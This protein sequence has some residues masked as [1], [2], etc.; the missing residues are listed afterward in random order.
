[1]NN[2]RSK[3]ILLKFMIFRD[4]V[5]IE[6]KTFKCIEKMNFTNLNSFFSFNNQY[7]DPLQF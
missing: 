4:K 6:L 3:H 5:T 7:Q 1:M 2:F